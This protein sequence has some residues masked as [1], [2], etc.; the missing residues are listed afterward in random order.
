MNSG[1]SK[2]MQ[3]GR[4]VEEVQTTYMG[5][6]LEMVEDYSYQQEWYNLSRDIK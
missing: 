4:E 1:K 2:I 3:I 5:L 6:I